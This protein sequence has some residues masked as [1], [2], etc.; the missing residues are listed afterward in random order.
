MAHLDFPKRRE[1]REPSHQVTSEVFG[2]SGGSF[3]S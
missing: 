1:S 3:I 2:N